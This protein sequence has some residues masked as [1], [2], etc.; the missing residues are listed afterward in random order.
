MTIWLQC[1][2]SCN[3]AY[4]PR[5]VLCARCGGDRFA[6]LEAE[7]GLVTEVTNLPEGPY[8]ASVVVQGVTV[9]AAADGPLVPGQSVT[10]DWRKESSSDKDHVFIAGASPEMADWLDG[11]QTKEKQ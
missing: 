4:F 5:R 8:I 1:C 3:A 10:V 6:P 9:I 2:S 7:D 11:R